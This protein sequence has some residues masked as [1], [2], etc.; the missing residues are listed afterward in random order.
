MSKKVA[1]SS[2]LLHSNEEKSYQACLDACI[3]GM[4]DFLVI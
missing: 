3:E 4:E 2:L 1:V